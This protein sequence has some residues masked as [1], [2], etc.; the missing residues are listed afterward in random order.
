LKDKGFCCIE[1]WMG[2]RN[3]LNTGDGVQILAP[4]SSL[5]TLFA[6]EVNALNR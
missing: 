3:S 2:P 5:D 6:I 1:P 4:G